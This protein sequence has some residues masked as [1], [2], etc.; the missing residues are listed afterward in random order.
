MCI[1][2]LL[3]SYVATVAALNAGTRNLDIART[4][5]GTDNDPY[6]SSK[7]VSRAEYRLLQH[8]FDHLLE[9]LQALMN[10]LSQDRQL[11]LKRI[12]EVDDRFK[13]FGAKLQ[14][15][16]S[17]KLATVQAANKNFSASYDRGM[18]DLYQRLVNFETISL[19]ALSLGKDL[20]T[21]M[22]AATL[23]TMQAPTKQAFA[24]VLTPAHAPP[25]R[26]TRRKH[27][28][29]D[30]AVNE[31]SIQMARL[32]D[33]DTEQEPASVLEDG[34][35][36]DESEVTEDESRDWASN[37]VSTRPDHLARFM[38]VPEVA[39]AIAKVKE[40][41]RGRAVNRNDD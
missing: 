20:S 30:L 15:D 1:R 29:D 21:Q 7:R 33:T 40:R 6:A 8:K 26:K 36:D 13:H 10:G 34:A 9:T 24:R 38:K 2:T 22:P 28:H 12:Q 32:S 11:Q 39:H 23:A 25:K 19:D 37:L 16:L 17:D 3:F 35:S 5:D 31:Q 41:L 4:E 18:A 27:M 14:A